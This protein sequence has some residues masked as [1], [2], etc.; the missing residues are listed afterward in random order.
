M[1]DKSVS[2]TI[3]SFI[4]EKEKIN[5]SKTN[6]YNKILMLQLWIGHNPLEVLRW[7][8]FYG[9]KK[10]QQQQ[11]N[12]KN[13]YEKENNPNKWVDGKLYTVQ[14]TQLLLYP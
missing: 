8:K 14:C 3:K 4:R 2:L 9:G 6:D 7:S 13:S 12:N 5:K 10:K 11:S 1:I